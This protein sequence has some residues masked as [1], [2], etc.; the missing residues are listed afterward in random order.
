MKN[1]ILKEN[2]IIALRLAIKKQEK[3]E[4]K[5]GYTGNSMLVAG[6]K[7]NLKSLESECIEVRENPVY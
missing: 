6:W 5:L 3:V 7:L 4:R 1:Y 2:L